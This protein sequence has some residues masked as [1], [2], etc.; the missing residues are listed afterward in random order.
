MDKLTA[1]FVFII[2]IA[3]FNNLNAWTQCD[4]KTW[5]HKGQE[6]KP[7]LYD[8]FE[9]GIPKTWKLQGK[10]KLSVN[11]I[12]YKLGKK[13]LQWDFKAG[14][15]IR[16]NNTIGDPS[17][18]GLQNNL[19]FA[20]FGIWVY[21]PKP[22]K[23]KSLRIEFYAGDKRTGYINFT[24]NYKGWQLGMV[25]HQGGSG[26]KGRNT[27]KVDN[28]RFA[29]P[30][31]TDGT[32][33]IDMV[34]YNSPR[35]YLFTNILPRE[36]PTEAKKIDDKK[37]PVPKT[38]SEADKKAIERIKRNLLF[39]VKITPKDSLKGTTAYNKIMKDFR[40]FK[41]TEDSHGMHGVPINNIFMLD[42]YVFFKN[43][44][45]PLDQVVDIYAGVPFSKFKL[46]VARNILCKMS[47]LSSGVTQEQYDNLAKVCVTIWKYLI[48]Q[49]FNPQG[50]KI[51]CHYRYF[52]VVGTYPFMDVLHKNGIG[53]EVFDYL[54]GG[55]AKLI[56][57]EG[58]V[59]NAH[60]DLFRNYINLYY[61]AM[62]YSDNPKRKVQVL[63]YLAK[64]LSYELSGDHGSVGF[65]PDGAGWRGIAFVFDYYKL[66]MY[67]L[68]VITYAI[69]DSSF[70][71][72]E[73]AYNT[74]KKSFL[75]VY[76]FSNNVEVPIFF[77]GTHPVSRVYKRGHYKYTCPLTRALRLLALAS[78][79]GC[80]KELAQAYVNLK[81]SKHMCNNG[82]Y[83]YD[84]IFEK[85]YGIKPSGPPQ[86][87]M[88]MNYAQLMAHRRKDWVAVTSFLKAGNNMRQR[89]NHYM[90]H[91][92]NTPLS[93]LGPGGFH[94]SGTEEYGWDWNRTN[95]TT[96]LYMP[97]L[98]NIKYNHECQPKPK[99][100]KRLRPTVFH[101]KRRFYTTRYQRYP[102]KDDP[103]EKRPNGGTS[104]R[105]T[106]GVFSD[107]FYEDVRLNNNFWGIKSYFFV[108]DRIY[109]VGS[110][111]FSDN[112]KYHCQTNLYQKALYKL[113]KVGKRKTDK[114]YK[115]VE[116]PHC[117][118]YVDGKKITAFPVPDKELTENKAHHLIDPQG[119]GYFVPKGQDVFVARK[120]QKSRTSNLNEHFD[121]EGDFA[122]AW[123][124]HGIACKD[125]KYVYVVFPYCNKKEFAE[126]SSKD[127]EILQ[128]DVK[129]HILH[130]KIGDFY[131]ASFF[132][133]GK[134]KNLPYVKNIEHTCQIIYRP[135]DGK[136][137][138]AVGDPD[139]H[140]NWS[141]DTK[142]CGEYARFG[143][144]SRLTP[145][146]VT[147]D[148][149]WKLEKPVDGVKIVSAK[150][151]ETVIEFAC[152]HGIEFNFTLIK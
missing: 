139:P 136:L 97:D 115:R 84:N 113:V 68:S 2:G 125:A 9:N 34:V 89:G 128:Q 114:D 102:S 142:H 138:M 105:N 100:F 40:E 63:R 93:I 141:D 18:T 17:L 104:W 117:A 69:H 56:V 130:D 49:G 65:K 21:V 41:I 95:G 146:K 87:N 103:F 109:A 98:I 36:T 61:L 26:I 140:R 59:T 6:P 60:T 112:K 71:L 121:H 127:F 137:E 38:I 54:E 3:V 99:G 57:D 42:Y 32:M 48:A 83:T 124:E 66:C 16:V 45:I 58:D 88:R 91:G 20:N 62:M 12:H 129:A 101:P 106:N 147:F 30:K 86:G 37:Y 126:F 131:M 92:Y 64:R 133:E 108:D 107:K 15:V 7:A 51:S 120:H 8:S 80:D 5:H 132:R 39:P 79:D 25:Q 19:C 44:K 13:S 70:A 85:K 110:N 75:A 144:K 1:V 94:A 24:L 31:D 145:M 43:A 76:F 111:I 53:K 74:L 67:P 150:N 151:N 46:S 11:S 77:Q 47:C 29:A 28:I 152:I 22:M 14:D 143:G 119:N 81:N 96:C 134:V 72:S 73:K 123:L 116:F 82:R 52:Y 149:V 118:T 148:G 122:T 135:K 33:L 35:Y 23:G 27:K 90:Y 78:P 10:G 50:P 4:P 55:L